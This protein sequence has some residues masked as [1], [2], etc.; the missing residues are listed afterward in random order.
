MMAK[1]NDD[2]GN[3]EDVGTALTGHPS[4]ESWFPPSSHLKDMRD[5][6]ADVNFPWVRLQYGGGPKAGESVQTLP[7]SYG[8][9]E[10][11]MEAYKKQGLP[12]TRESLH[13]PGDTALGVQAGVR[14]IHAPTEQELLRFVLGELANKPKTDVPLPK[15]RPVP[16]TGPDI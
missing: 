14:D 12:A 13:E 11:M 2:D 10:A 9:G 6:W 8:T 15:R 1:K 16:R 5:D 7:Q 4:G 3:Y